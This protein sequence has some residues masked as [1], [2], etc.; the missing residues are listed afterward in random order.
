MVITSR[1]LLPSTLAGLVAVCAVSCAALDWHLRAAH[2]T[3]PR[4]DEFLTEHPESRHRTAALDTLARWSLQHHDHAVRQLAARA[5]AKA[6]VEGAERLSTLVMEEPWDSRALRAALAPTMHS[7][8]G[9]AHIFLSNTDPQIRVLAAEALSGHQGTYSRSTNAKFAAALSDG[10]LDV[11]KAAARSLLTLDYDL[12]GELV[13]HRIVDDASLR[14]VLSGEGI[15]AAP[16]LVSLLGNESRAIRSGAGEALVAMGDPVIPV[17]AE[18]LGHGDSSMRPEI[19]RVLGKTGH[20]GAAAPLI[21][22]LCGRDHKAV[23]GAAAGLGDLG[24]AAVEPLLA[25]LDGTP[26]CEPLGRGTAAQVLATIGDPRAQPALWRGLDDP[27]GHSRRQY[28]SALEALLPSPADTLA[29]V[30]LARRD[31]A[32][33]AGAYRSVILAG[34][35]G[36]EELLVG[37]LRLFFDTRMLQTLLNCQ[38]PIVYS[39]AREIAI[40]RGYTVTTFLHG[41]PP[42]GS[43]AW[44]A[45]RRPR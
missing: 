18:A 30:A 22:A 19:A 44:G 23:H 11:R 31:T 3:V 6:G 4:I 21:T 41:T 29:A 13:G 5:L 28:A 14:A 33:V 2:P 16:L 40:K 15:A 1:S 32:I 8:R 43:P 27:S 7:M 37:A 17:L 12:A 10:N 35:P 38:N 20:P 24:P 42:S 9:G 26:P 36:S 34:R 25:L 45:A 39:R